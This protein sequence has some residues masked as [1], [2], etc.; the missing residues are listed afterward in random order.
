MADPTPQPTQF[1]VDI[2]PDKADGIYSNLAFLHLS[3]S[4]FILDFARMMPGVPR[5]K[6]QSRIILTP[7]SAKGLLQLLEANVKNFES[8]HG[9]IKDPRASGGN[10][11]GFQSS[12]PAADSN[13]TG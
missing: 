13:S 12:P 9:E 2:D 4:E 10:A 11:I 5:A 7:Q 3:A 6:V 8:Q 1:Q